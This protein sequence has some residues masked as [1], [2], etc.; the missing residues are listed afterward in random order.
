M[1]LPDYI[2]DRVTADIRQQMAGILALTE[3]LARQRLT[4][5]AQ[6]CLAGVSEAADAV[7]RTLDAALDI[8]AVASDGLALNPAPLVLRDLMDDV[9]ARWRAAAGMAG[10]T[11]LVSYDG[12]PEACVHADRARLTQV[13]DA[14]IAEAVGGARRGAVE[15]S[16]RAEEGPAGLRLT[17]RIRGARDPARDGRGLEARVREVDSQFGL[18]VALGVLLA[19]RI[20]QEL[21][22]RIGEETNPGAGQTVAFELD[23]PKARALPEPEPRSAGRSAHVLVVDDNATNRMVAQALCEMFDC[24]SESAVDGV[25][26]LE[27]ARAGRFDLILMDIK[28]PRMDGIS[29]ARA[30]RDLPGEAGEVP[31]VALTA[32]ADPDDAADYLAAGMDGVV[33]KP[34]K[35]EHLLAV[36]R[37]AL[38]AQAAAA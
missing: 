12:A 15:A 19:R 10:V 23:L 22:G 5:D 14:F 18:E 16:L 30:I 4:P 8:H 6:A 38:D 32:N 28:M 25:E 17:G 24:T 29:A 13:F 34:M 20:V 37:Q 35:P 2:F 31:I 33:E 36:L 11:L 3:Q 26:A 9:E 21:G 7:R 27:A 1:S